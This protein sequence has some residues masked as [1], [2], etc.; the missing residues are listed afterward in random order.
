M[1]IFMKLEMWIDVGV[2]RF[3]DYFFPEKPDSEKQNGGHLK[4]SWLFGGGF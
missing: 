3:D 1:Q 4:F 2:S